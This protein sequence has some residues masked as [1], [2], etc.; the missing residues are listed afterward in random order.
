M[1]HIKI[2]DAEFYYELHGKGSPLV[3]IAG[4]AS[5]HSFWMPIISKLDQDF[6]VLIFD[7]RAIGQ[8]KEAGHFPLTADIMA[9][10]VM[11]L[12]RAVGFVKPHI[13]GQSMGGTVAQRIAARYPN[14]IS[15]LVILTS[16]LKWRQ[17]MLLGLKSILN[18]QREQGSFDTVFELMRALFLNNPFPPVFGKPRAT[19]CSIRIFYVMYLC[20]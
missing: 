13:V 1:P 15:K 20:F 5:D 17:S 18:V 12:I 14:E 16:T 8:T 9:E 10:D 7:H 6:Q 11:Q 3:L 19:I 2:N 4:Y